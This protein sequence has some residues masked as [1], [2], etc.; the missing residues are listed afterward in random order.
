M[1]TLTETR[2]PRK[3]ETARHLCRSILR[4]VRCLPPGERDTI[5][6]KYHLTYTLA[7]LAAAHA[8]A[9]PT[10]AARPR[11]YDLW[12][13][14][15]AAVERHIAVLEIE[16][17][18][19]PLAPPAACAGAMPACA[20]AMS[21]CAGGMSVEMDVDVAPTV[22]PGRAIDP[23]QQAIDPSQQPAAGAWRN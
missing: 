19:L 5:R 4:L 10:A 18:A 8:L 16:R 20:G 11:L 22:V 6:A 1:A 12:E 2:K 14:A 23:S 9:A 17:S 3:G 21:A 15:Q 13:A 7:K